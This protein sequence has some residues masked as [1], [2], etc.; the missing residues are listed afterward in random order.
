[1]EIGNWTMKKEEIK[2]IIAEHLIMQ[3]ALIEIRDFGGYLVGGIENGRPIN[4][5]EV[6]GRALLRVSE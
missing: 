1:M 5:S 2:R 4:P 3:V 6:A